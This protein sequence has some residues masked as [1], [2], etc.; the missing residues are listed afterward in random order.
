MRDAY[1]DL[2]CDCYQIPETTRDLLWGIAFTM[3]EMSGAQKL[4]DRVLE[5]I[6]N[7]LAKREG[8]ENEIHRQTTK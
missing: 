2:A 8:V 6:T 5:D 4:K 1:F 7:G 3:G